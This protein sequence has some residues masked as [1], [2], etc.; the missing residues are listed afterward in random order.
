[1]LASPHSCLC[2]IV[3]AC[4]HEWVFHICAILV[5]LHVWI[6]PTPLRRLG[7]RKHQLRESHS[8]IELIDYVAAEIYEHQCPKPLPYYS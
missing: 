1:M 4:G 8:T 6:S 3:I 5:S 7:T 2:S